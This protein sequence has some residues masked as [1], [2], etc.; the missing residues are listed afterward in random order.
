MPTV[1]PQRT[2]TILRGMRQ[3][4][5]GI[6]LSR[7]F[8]WDEIL[9]L[10]CLYL[11]VQ[12]LHITRRLHLPFQYKEARFTVEIKIL[13]LTKNLVNLRALLIVGQSE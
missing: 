11:I 1:S 6:I 3:K 7:L 13:L 12:T 4:M 2:I 10:P 5:L 9:R 8:R